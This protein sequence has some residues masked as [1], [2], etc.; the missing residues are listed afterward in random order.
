MQGKDHHGLVAFV[1]K[2]PI[3]HQTAFQRRERANQRV[4]YLR[5]VCF[6]HAINPLD[7]VLQLQA[8]AAATLHDVGKHFALLLVIV[9]PG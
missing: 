6:W 8:S 2:K 7:F 9:K 4:A 5:V 1:E 3:L